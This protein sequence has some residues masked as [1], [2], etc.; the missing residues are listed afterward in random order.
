M[1]RIYQEFKELKQEK[2]WALDLLSTHLNNI[3]RHKYNKA[4]KSNPTRISAQI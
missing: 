3:W 4:F 1:D 2:I